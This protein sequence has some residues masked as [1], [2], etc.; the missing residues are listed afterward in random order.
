MASKFLIRENRMDK[1]TTGIIA[2]SLSAILCACPGFFGICFGA[3]SALA[4]FVPGA[5][6]DIFGSSSPR[7]A[8][9][10]GIGMLCLGIVFVAIPV[11]VGLVTLRGKKSEAAVLPDEPIPPAI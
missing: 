6:I 10:T 11:V 2:T 9:S 7:A 5:E 1:K 4:S 3:I 8:L